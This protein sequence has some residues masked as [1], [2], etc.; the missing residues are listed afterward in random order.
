M[1]IDITIPEVGESISE[2]QIGEWRKSEGDSVEQDEA[3]V[4]LET[5]K[6]SVEL[7]APA[8]G[9]LSQITKQSGQSAQVGDVI[10]SIEDDG[11]A[12]EP[13]RRKKPTEEEPSAKGGA[14]ESKDDAK[15]PEEA[16]AEANDEQ[17]AAEAP[18]PAGDEKPKPEE[19]GREPKRKAKP[20]GK[21]TSE[22][23]VESDSSRQAPTDDAETE[24]DADDQHRPSRDEQA[25]SAKDQD[26]EDKR[27]KDRESDTTQTRPVPED[28]D[29]EPR[30][31]P[32]AKR[33]LSR[34]GLRPADVRG[35]GPAG[36]ITEADVARHYTGKSPV[37]P[38]QT[39]PAAPE[40]PPSTPRK[41][42][43]DRHEE[44]VPM[45]RLRRG[46]AT[47]LVDAQQTA[48]LLTTFNEIDM[49]AIIRLRSRYGPSFQEKFGVRLGFMSFFVKAAVEALKRVPAVNAE[50]RGDK[51]AYRDFFDIGVAVATDHGLVVPVIIDADLLSFAEIERA[52]ADFA[53]RA[54][55]KRL[56]PDELEGGTF[57]LTNGGVYGSLLSTPIVNPPQSGIL[58]LHTVQERPVAREGVFVRPMMYVALT[59]DHRIIDGR[60]AVT[61]LN[62]I[63]Q[64]AEDPAGIL[65]DL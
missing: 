3:I 22:R 13:E 59:Y 29:V 14:E 37:E 4:E 30:V 43:D 15:E 12:A 60:Q 1:A 36:R 46:I 52:I 58:G 49:S 20:N 57:T 42:P 23:D 48:A 61:F 31:M 63:K 19:V 35:T 6:A 47:R 51:I 26:G 34:S 50:V 54:R 9:T 53:S 41:A 18:K 21:D 24:T 38:A 11:E 27:Q 55:A 45:S 40:P 10:G 2:V 56:A 32:A 62:S 25:E 39:E 8:G 16:E 17:D 44:I 33:A 64:Y 65:L 28:V 7:P 5:D